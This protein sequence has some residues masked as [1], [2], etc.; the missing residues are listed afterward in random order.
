MARDLAL[1]ILN[2][3]SKNSAPLSG[4]LEQGFKK[5]TD[6]DDRDRAFAVHL[7]QGAL[8]WQ[9]RL[10][11]ILKQHLRFSFNKIDS[12]VLN[13]I[14]L[15]LFQIFFLDRVPDRA[16]VD[17]A[18]KQ[19]KRMARPHVVR[20][21]NGILREICRKKGNIA[22]PD[23]QK[24]PERYQSIFY[25]YPQWMVRKWTRELGPEKTEKLLNAQ[26]TVSPMTIRTNT[27]KTT[28]KALIRRLADEQVTAAPTD[29]APEGLNLEHF[30]G[31][32]ARLNAFRDGL[33]QIQGEAAQVCSHLLC[34]GTQHQILDI[35]AGLGGK[36]T[37]LAQITGDIGQI[38]AV[39]N[40][41]E[42]L[43]NLVKNN[44]R[45]GIRSVHPVALN[46]LKPLTFLR[47]G[48]KHMLVDAPCSGLGVIGRHPDIKHNRDE[49][50]IARLS[51][52]QQSILAHSCEVLAPGGKMLY[53][54]CTI[55]IEEN[56]K[57]VEDFLR[58]RSD[59]T[60]INLKDRVP[61]WGETLINEQGFLRTFP[62]LHQMDGFFA[63]LFEKKG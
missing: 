15:A 53:V 25:A 55:S 7:V 60:L 12:Q 62:H 46:A 35:C 1:S 24:E 45:L 22:Y 59:F 31:S 47:I 42:R 21:V 30:Q 50:Q 39:D 58:R 48:T 41:M 49:G 28:R 18:V 32:P 9:I 5:R 2:N 27:L 63:A 51:R 33:F 20:F 19:V 4:P 57:G 16:S 13:A 54:T 36:S 8:R 43:K 37:H 52:M 10:D 6:L 61:S 17:E 38:I 26:N 3:I 14:R 56:E 29:F 11:W 34:D 23:A 44:R 40:S